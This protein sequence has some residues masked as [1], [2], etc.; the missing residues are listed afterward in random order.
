MTEMRSSQI[1][2]VEVG[3]CG[4]RISSAVTSQRTLARLNG[5]RC[6]ILLTRP[7]NMVLERLRIC[8][9]LM[10]RDRYIVVL[11]MGKARVRP[12]KGTVSVPRL[13]FTPATLATKIGRFVVQ[14]SKGRLEV[15]SVTSWTDSMILL[16][17]IA[18]ETQRFVKLRPYGE[19]RILSSGAMYSRSSTQWIMLLRK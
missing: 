15:H 14:E 2:Y 17:Y 11:L 13:E 12:L 3:R 5:Q 9:S 16:K 10:T 18:N 8:A 1:N 19:C 6:T 4:D 7:K